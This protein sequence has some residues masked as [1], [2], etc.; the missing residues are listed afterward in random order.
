MRHAGLKVI[1]SVMGLVLAGNLA[2]CADSS[3]KAP[4]GTTATS[5]L[6]TKEHRDNYG[7]KKL[8]MTPDGSSFAGAVVA[9]E[10]TAALIA[11]DV[12]AKGGN[13]ADAATAL[14]FA[15]SVTYPAAACRVVKPC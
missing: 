11:R 13:A 10:P 12:L 8:A 1:G 9:D 6:E 15:L 4:L 2:G 5:S 3:S 7:A 14:Y